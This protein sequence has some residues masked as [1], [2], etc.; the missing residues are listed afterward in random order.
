MTFL[1][2]TLDN[3]DPFFAPVIAP[4]FYLQYVEVADQ[5]PASG[6]L[7]ANI[8]IIRRHAQPSTDVNRMI[9]SENRAEL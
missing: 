4:S 3:T 1:R 6:S 2:Q 8:R 9:L 5:D 7:Y